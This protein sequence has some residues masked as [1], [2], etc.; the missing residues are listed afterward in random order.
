M[1]HLVPL[2]TTQ[3]PLSCRTASEASRCRRS[4]RART[5]S[6]LF[7]QRGLEHLL[8]KGQRA[9]GAT[10]AWHSPLPACDSCLQVLAAGAAPPLI[11][12]LGTAPRFH[13][14]SHRALH[15]ARA[16]EYQCRTGFHRVSFGC[17][18][19]AVGSSRQKSRC[20]GESSNVE[21]QANA[22][23]ALQSICFQ[24]DGRG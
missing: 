15:L 13:G 20:A 10:P 3:P 23:G 21:L 4:A 12:F 5:R 19:L 11:S 14:T 7:S 9:H 8:R 16:C 1:S 18:A 24:K 2:L 17:A 6:H 22:A